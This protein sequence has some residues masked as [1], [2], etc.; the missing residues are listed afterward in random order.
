VDPAAAPVWANP[1]P[2]RRAPPPDQLPRDR[3]GKAARRRE[4][5]RSNEERLSYAAAR[6]KREEMGDLAEGKL[7]L[8]L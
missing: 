7:R 8:R 6:A 4:H 2:I 3:L 1:S 5:A